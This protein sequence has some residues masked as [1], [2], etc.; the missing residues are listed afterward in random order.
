VKNESKVKSA[1]LV[2]PQ[3]DTSASKRIDCHRFLNQVSCVRTITPVLALALASQLAPRIYAQPANNHAVF[4][5]TNSVVGNQIIA[6]SRSPNGSLV[7]QNQYATGGRGSGGTIDP[8]ASQGSLT[9]SQD[10]SLLFAVNAGDGTISVFRVNGANLQFVQV[11]SSGGSAPVALAQHGNLVYVINSAGN[12]NVVGFNLDALG[13]LV[14]IPNSI[15]YLSATNTFPSSLAFSPD[16]RFLLLTEKATN[17]IDVFSVNGDGSLSQPTFTP[18]PVPGLFDVVFS[19]NGAALILQTGGSTTSSAS[20]VSSYL[21]QAGSTLSPVTASVP[22]LGTFACWIALTPD[23]QFAYVSN[24]I[25]A[26]IS[27]FAI[28]TSGTVTALPGTIV[29]SLP[30][31]SFNLDIAVSQDAKYVYTMN[32]GIGTIGIF[33]VQPNGS[34]RFTGSASGLSANAGFEGLA[35]F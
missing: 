34:L 17:N 3:E 12:S 5:M 30:A 7:E 31:G 19:P 10:R 9:L 28:G 22:T 2:N 24:T 33:A 8:L 29:G 14:M 25:S 23:G 18:D 32:S 11:V 27:A 1:Q 15:R 16:G 26:T 20:S 6:Y 35:A 21:V 4:A 13:Q